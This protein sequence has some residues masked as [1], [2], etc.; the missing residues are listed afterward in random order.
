MIG[1]AKRTSPIET[2]AWR[3]ALETC[4][5]SECLAIGRLVW[6][7]PICPT[8]LSAPAVKT[9]NVCRQGGREA[10]RLD[11][12]REANPGRRVLRDRMCGLEGLLV[13]S[14]CQDEVL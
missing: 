12:V 13:V 14:W 2:G 7:S 1:V 9:P 4:C 10:L 8:T 11:V 5:P 6:A 3:S